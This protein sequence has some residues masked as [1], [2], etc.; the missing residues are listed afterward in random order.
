[1]KSLSIKWRISIW[2][3]AV[4][5]TVITVISIVSSLEFEESHLR[6]IGRTLTAISDGI[7][8]SLDSQS[9]EK[10]WKEEVN[11]LTAI[12]ESNFETLYRIWLEGE[13]EDLL[14]SETSNTTYSRWLHELNKQ[15]EP[16]IGESS[17]FN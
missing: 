4:I 13:P 9:D 15:N 3:T 6:N 1:M 7:V 8:A 2:I 17:F 16:L 5:I 11:R 12:S 10:K 14:T